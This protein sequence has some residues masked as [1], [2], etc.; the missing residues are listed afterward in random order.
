MFAAFSI[1][2]IPF[3]PVTYRAYNHLARLSHTPEPSSIPS[4][5][6]HS[7]VLLVSLFL[8]PRRRWRSSPSL[9][10]H[11]LRRLDLRATHCR[12]PSSFP[13]PVFLSVVASRRGPHPISLHR[14]FIIFM[15]L[16]SPVIPLIRPLVLYR[17][18]FTHPPHAC[19]IPPTTPFPLSRSSPLS[20]SPAWTFTIRVV[21]SIPCLAFGD[22]VRCRCAAKIQLLFFPTL[23]SLCER[24]WVILGALSACDGAWPSRV[25][26]K[27]REE[28]A[29]ERKARGPV[30]RKCY[31]R[32]TK[33]GKDWAA[34]LDRAHACD[35]H[36]GLLIWPRGARRRGLS[37]HA[38]ARCS[39][40]AWIS[41]GSLWMFL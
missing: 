18:L 9:S 28:P 5:V 14:A 16:Q 13:F 27:G 11:P 40:E 32:A 24:E 6:Y 39:N 41:V 10:F 17:S 37:C 2:L 38:T 31:G 22:V 12:L 36:L 35:L 8:S 19:T 29:G 1:I 34:A 23:V 20:R 3:P 15:H 7:F 21:H 25:R 30:Q 33:R 4:T 26:R